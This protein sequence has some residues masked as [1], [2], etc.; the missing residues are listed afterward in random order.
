MPESLVSILIPAFNAERWLAETF[1][2]AVSQT[3]PRKEIIV[4]DDGSTD[5]TLEIAR[6]FESASVKVVTQR[7]QGGSA[8]R[9]KAF[10]L[11]QG[12]YIQWLDADDLLAPQKITNQM[13][14]A[15]DAPS[16]RTL[17]SGPWGAFIHRPSTA[18]FVPSALW[19]DLTPAE[20]LLLKMGHNL[21][22]PPATWL[23]SRELAE[24]AGP[25][26]PAMVVDDDGEYFCRV[27]C[28]SDGIRF[29]PE[30]KIY[31]RRTGLGSVSYIGWSDR[32][33]EA[34]WRSIKL[35]IGYLRSI[36]DSER[37]R[38]A[39]VR[40]MQTWFGWFYP[41]RSDIVNE[42]ERMA[43][44]LGGCLH[45]PQL[46][47]KYSWIKSLFGWLPAKHA[48]EFLPIVKFSLQRRLDGMVEAFEVSRG[49]QESRSALPGSGPV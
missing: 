35:H 39:C 20:F 31:Y 22:M 23:V 24:I 37:V 33:I 1:R 45:P 41:E 29:V 6:Q 46:S 30:A 5:R 14:E 43:S 4:V 36:E 21:Y 32:K 49:P 16:L 10:S 27:L 44:E 40:F 18:R 26:D 2:S 9:N 25:W 11:C 34:Q 42:A 17:F 7:N 48:Q 28:A 38:S 15:I 47:W 8:A 19:S 3:W 12:T 13:W